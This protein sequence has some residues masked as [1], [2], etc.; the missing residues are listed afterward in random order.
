MGMTTIAQVLPALTVL[1]GLLLGVRWFARRG[2]GDRPGLRVR[3]RA[4]LSRSAVVAVVEV[5]GRRFLV[6]SSDDHLTLLSELESAEPTIEPVDPSVPHGRGRPHQRPRTG[7]VDQ[8]RAM[9][10]RS[11]VERNLRAHVAD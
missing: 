6:G 8:L 4:S 10:V 9:T 2:G 1:V 3:A 5:D 11:H 7:L